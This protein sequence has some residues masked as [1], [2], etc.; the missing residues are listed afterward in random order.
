MDKLYSQSKRPNYWA[1]SIWLQITNCSQLL[2]QLTNL[3]QLLINLRFVDE[4]EVSVSTIHNLSSKHISEKA[5]IKKL[6]EDIN[7]ICDDYKKT[8]TGT[9]AT[10]KNKSIRASYLVISINQALGAIFIIIAA[11]TKQLL[12]YGCAAGFIGFGL[13]KNFFLMRT[14]KKVK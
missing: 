7:Q 3:V 14:L 6:Q 5:E 9:D 2:G 4:H 11:Y 10:P 1:E 8:K 12:W 13:I